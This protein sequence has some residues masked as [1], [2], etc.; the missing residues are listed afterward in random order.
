M[1]VKV[2]KKANTF[3]E[4]ADDVI[5]VG[6]L[7]EILKQY[8]P[9]AE[10]ITEQV[11]INDKDEYIDDYTGKLVGLTY[12]GETQTD[13]TKQNCIQVNLKFADKRDEVALK[14]QILLDEKED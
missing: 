6:E 14:D 4:K 1:K 2:D 7:I 13:F 9:E 12:L 10:V 8:N 5:T 11:E 3:V